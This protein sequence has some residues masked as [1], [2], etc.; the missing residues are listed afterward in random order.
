MD[1]RVIYADNAATTA[2]TEEVLGAMLPYFCEEYGNPSSIYKAGRDARKAVE[3]AREKVAKAI[4]ATPREIYFTSCGSESD[5]WAVKGAAELMAEQGKRHIVTSAIEHHAVFR[6]CKYLESRGFKV[7]YLPVGADGAV[8]VNDAE[9][10]IRGDTALVTV[11]YA[12]NETGVIQPVSELAE[13]CKAK[14]VLF[15]TDAVQAVGHV[16]IDV[17]SLGADMLSLS[18][19]KFHAPKG[20]GALYVRSGI[21]LPNVIHGGGQ[22]RGRRAGTENVPAIVGLG[23]A[24]EAAVCDIS[25]REAAI[26]AVRDKLAEGLLEIPHTRLNGSSDK[27]LAGTLNISFEGIDGEALALVLGMKGIYVSSGS[28]CTSGETAPS[29]VLLAMGLDEF[30]AKSAIRLSI[31]EDITEADAAYMIGTIKAV[32]EKL[33]RSSP[34]WAHIIKNDNI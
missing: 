12:N 14:G 15:H 31:G 33:R 32:T 18:G 21:K 20:V 1:N 30:T 8:S 19:H 17:H 22:E 6:T 28:A 9:K 25:R 34:A 29:H 3:E 11:M 7:T 27:R 24:I 23:A 2:V 26:S 4:G 10:A 16:E 13:I 5:N